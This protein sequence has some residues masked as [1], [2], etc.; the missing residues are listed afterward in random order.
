MSYTQILRRKFSRT[1]RT[2]RV[3][4]AKPG[5]PP[6]AM[7]VAPAPLAVSLG[8]RDRNRIPI[9]VSPIPSRQGRRHFR[10][11]GSG[12]LRGVA[13][14]QAQGR[15]SAVPAMLNTPQACQYNN[16]ACVS[17]LAYALVRCQHN[18]RRN[19]SVTRMWQ[20]RLRGTSSWDYSV[21]L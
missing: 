6:W 7:A 21:H 16:I 19:T 2:Q 10:G 12:P 13:Y 3:P 4:P 11:R 14:G 15:T 18:Y 5:W 20:T 8:S 9:F 17:D 1:Y